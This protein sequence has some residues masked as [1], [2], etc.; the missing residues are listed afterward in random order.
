MEKILILGG[1]NFIGRNLVE[2]LIAEDKYDLCLLNRATSNPSIFP[3][4]QRIIGD[5][6]TSSISDLIKGDWDY[7]IDLSAYYPRSV[8]YILQGLQ[9]KLKNYIFISTCS[10]YENGDPILKLESA[11]RK[12]CNN[13]DYNDE[14][15]R[16]YGERK[17]A[18]EDLIISSGLPYT[19]LRPSLVYGQYDNTDRFY[20]WLHQVKSYQNIIIPNNGV[21]RFSVTYIHDLT[22][23]II[24]SLRTKESN[25]IYNIISQA[26]ISIKEIIDISSRILGKSPNLVN[27]P[28][29]YLLDNS[30]SEWVEMPLW[31]NHNNFTFSNNKM[32]ASFNHKIIELETSVQATIKYYNTLKWPEPKYGIS[33]LK[34]LELLNS[35]REYKSKLGSK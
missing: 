26:E 5:R 7:V 21:Q 19:I 22:Q 1:T 11:R 13:E 9:T 30:I 8:E 3:E 15:I 33:R 35:F 25:N 10:V 12:R 17:V 32:K 27:L 23:T 29:E 16:S 20:Y 14:T 6:N 18:C 24:E 4:I 28:S 34:Q 2:R 31:L